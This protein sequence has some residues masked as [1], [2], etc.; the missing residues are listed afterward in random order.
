MQT[1]TKFDQYIARKIHQEGDKFDSTALDER[2]IPYFNSG[3]RIKVSIYGE[4]L[5]GT[6]GVTSGWRPVFLLMRTS[7]SLGSV[8]VLNSDALITA[9]KHGRTHV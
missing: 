8:D 6:V 9:A 7:R 4:T 3:A 5:T 2:F 1:R